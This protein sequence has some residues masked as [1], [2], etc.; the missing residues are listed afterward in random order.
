MAEWHLYLSRFYE[1]KRSFQRSY[2]H[3]LRY[4]AL[5]DSIY[6]EENTVRTTQQQLNYE[7]DKRSAADSVKNA[8][9]SKQAQFRHDEEMSHQRGLTYA[10]IVGFAAMILITTLSYRAYKAKIRSNAEIAKQKERV[11]EKQ[12]EIMDSIHYAKRIQQSLL[13][14][15]KYIA[16]RLKQQG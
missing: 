2:E 14:T 10:G 16:K 12:K 7:F 1:S 8:E 4:F 6:N 3:Y 9:A 13:P 15:E 5:K 11:E